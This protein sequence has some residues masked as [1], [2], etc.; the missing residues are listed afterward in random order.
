M[1]LLLTFLLLTLTIAMIAQAWIGVCAR[2][3]CRKRH[4]FTPEGPGATPGTTLWRR[5]SAWRYANFQDPANRWTGS[6]VRLAFVD[7]LAVLVCMGAL[8]LMAWSPV[9]LTLG[10]GYWAVALLAGYW[11][12]GSMK[13]SRSSRTRGSSTAAFLVKSRRLMPDS[14]GLY[15]I[16]DREISNPSLLP[17]RPFKP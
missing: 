6:E 4:V 14:N 16:A 7:S 15:E 11:T 13:V 2:L 8:L 3:G 12:R 5:R 17:P 10:L 9:L 1:G